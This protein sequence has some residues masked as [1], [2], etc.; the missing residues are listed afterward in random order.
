MHP[1][2]PAVRDA[3]VLD[4]ARLHLVILRDDLIVATDPITGC[5]VSEFRSMGLA[6]SWGGG[7]VPFV[8]RRQ[9]LTADEPAGGPA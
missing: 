4:K 5:I 3:E 7:K 9:P 8:D 1:P 2:S 6:K